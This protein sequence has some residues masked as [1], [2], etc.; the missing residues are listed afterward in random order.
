MRILYYLT[1]HGFGH[2]CRAWAIAQEFSSDV[3][4]LFRTALPE[5]VFQEEVKRPFSF[6]PAE[7][8]CGCVQRDG[9]TLDP[10]Q[11][12]KQYMSIA[13][14]NHRRIAEEIDWIRAH[15]IDGLVAD[16]PP[17]P[18][19]VAKRAGVP[20]IAV[21]NFTWYDIYEP[22]AR[23]FPPFQPYLEQI[24]EQYAMADLLLALQ[25][26]LE[27]PYFPQRIPMPLVGRK[28]R[29]LRSQVIQEY[30]LH[31][32]KHLGLI[33]TGNYGMDRVPWKN[34]E[35]FS[36]WE[37]IGIYPLPGN[38]ANY[39]LF[40]RGSITYPDLIASAEVM[41]SKIGYATVAECLINGTPLIFLP[42]EHFVEYPFLESEVL[43]RG[44]GHKLPSEDYYA[45]RWDGA[46]ERGLSRPRPR[47]L[48]SHGARLCARAIEDFI[49]KGKLP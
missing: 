25:P 44:Y 17:F 5:D 41:V 11:T 39:H 34:L 33:Y 26:A 14:R 45:L 12:L 37:F 19:E 13:E 28:G 47:P 3:E 24:R 30:G 46:L 21:T 8:D 4:V 23:S 27:M 48:D 15:R 43:R 9:V 29:S 1:P 31:P 35:R 36:S 38:P 42:R 22:L 18:L 49:G 2:A 32:Q 10:I 16:I 7:F 40:Q 6:F 20:S